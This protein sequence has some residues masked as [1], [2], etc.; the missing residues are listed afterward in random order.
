MCLKLVIVIVEQSYTHCEL[1]TARFQEMHE[2]KKVKTYLPNFLLNISEI[3]N[4]WTKS[5]KS[6]FATLVL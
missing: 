6:C 3:N 5:I 1:G 4:S 2:K